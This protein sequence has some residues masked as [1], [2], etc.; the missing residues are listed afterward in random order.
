MKS[1]N[2]TLILMSLNTN[3]RNQKKYLDI[4]S[5]VE[6]MLD[7]NHVFIDSLTMHLILFSLKVKDFLTFPPIKKYQM[8][9]YRILSERLIPLFRTTM[10]FTT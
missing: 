6:G 5:R 10:S 3:R 1:Q 4:Q 9:F 2:L 7:L 8:I